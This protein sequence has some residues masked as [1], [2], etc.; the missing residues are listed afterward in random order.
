MSPSSTRSLSALIALGL[1]VGLGGS[2]LARAPEAIR[3]PYAYPIK[4]GLVYRTAFYTGRI[5]A[6]KSIGAKPLKV[7]GVFAKAAAVTAAVGLSLYGYEA[8][9]MA[10]VDNGHAILGGLLMATPMVATTSIF[11]PLPLG[12]LLYPM[13]QWVLGWRA[14]KKGWRDTTHS[15]E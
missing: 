1:L 9:G 2:A 6:G 8:G 5:V 11:P 10:L 14:G 4:Q 7:A 12:N 15:P 13:E 3:N